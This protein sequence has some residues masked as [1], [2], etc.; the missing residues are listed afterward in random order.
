MNYYLFFHLFF[1]SIINFLGASWSNSTLIKSV[2]ID[3]TLGAMFDFSF[4]DINNDGKIDVLATNHVDNA[5]SGVY[6][7][8]FFFFLYFIYFDIYIILL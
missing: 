1:I 6:L 5:N 4:F 2:V 7:F 8:L 3:K